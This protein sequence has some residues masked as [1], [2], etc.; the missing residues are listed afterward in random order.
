MILKKKNMK[1]DEKILHGMVMTMCMAEM[2]KCD[3][4]LPISINPKISNNVSETY[5]KF[6]DETKDHDEL[7]YMA[8]SAQQ[9]FKIT[10]IEEYLQ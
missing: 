7:I 3:G 2:N 10:I 6:V 5:R 8:N 4:N 1:C 9:L